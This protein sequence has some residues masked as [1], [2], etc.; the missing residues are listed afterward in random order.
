V[1]KPVLC[2]KYAGVSEL[3]EDGV[4]GWVFDPHNPKELAEL[5]KR[6]LDNPALISA[7]GENAQRKMEAFTP[8]AAAEFLGRVAIWVTAQ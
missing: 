6:F 4:N 1:G 8:E 7:M 3:V 5:M 2:S